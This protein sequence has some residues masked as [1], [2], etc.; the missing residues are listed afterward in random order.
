MT[1][2]AV[3]I[4]TDFALGYRHDLVADDESRQCEAVR[5]PSAQ[6]RLKGRVG[7]CVQRA[8][9]LRARAWRLARHP[10]LNQTKL[11]ARELRGDQRN[12]NG[13]QRAARRRRKRAQPLFDEVRED[14]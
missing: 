4:T 6:E 1:R 5:T 8:R 10:R 7:A 3:A 11:S 14:L 9:E 2:S 12:G 13:R